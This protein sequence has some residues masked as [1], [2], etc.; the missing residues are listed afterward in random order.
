MS[1]SS[2]WEKLSDEQKQVVNDFRA[3]VSD[4]LKENLEPFY[5]QHPELVFHWS[6]TMDIFLRKQE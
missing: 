3:R 6:L 2:D 4:I 1:D 5:Q